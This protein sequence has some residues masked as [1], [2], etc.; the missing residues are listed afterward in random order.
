[1][2]NRILVE[3]LVREKWTGSWKT[4]S[5]KISLEKKR[6]NETKNREERGSI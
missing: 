5:N 4:W 1:M 2:T 6:R 3:A